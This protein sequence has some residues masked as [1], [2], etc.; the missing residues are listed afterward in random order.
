MG[1]PI[2]IAASRRALALTQRPHTCASLGL[3]AIGC[4]HAYQA[5]R[6]V[7]SMVETRDEHVKQITYQL[8]YAH[9]P[10]L[11]RVFSEYFG[12]SPREFRRFL[13]APADL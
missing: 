11:T 2:A 6:I 8:G 13:I 1:S 3:T 10:N 12:L 7:R 4:W 9:P 5:R